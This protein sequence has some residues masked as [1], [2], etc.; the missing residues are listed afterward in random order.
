MWHTAVHPAVLYVIYEGEENRDKMVYGYLGPEKEI[1][2]K[3]F[4]TEVVFD[5][6]P[7]M[8]KKKKKKEV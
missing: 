4:V 1:T 2:F 6:R 3:I 8:K 7:K 5:L